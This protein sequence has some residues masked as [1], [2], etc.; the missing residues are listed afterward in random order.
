VIFI[1][2]FFLIGVTTTNVHFLSFIFALL[3]LARAEIVVGIRILRL[4][5]SYVGT[6]NL[7]GY[8]GIK[9]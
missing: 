3:G 2:R 8:R 1:I 9:F 7:V 5:F 6:L 4:G